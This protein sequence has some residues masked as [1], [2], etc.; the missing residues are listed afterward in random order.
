MS[1]EAVKS[2]QSL[3]NLEILSVTD[4]VY[5]PTRTSLSNLLPCSM[6][7]CYSCNILSLRMVQNSNGRLQ[8]RQATQAYAPIS[9]DHSSLS[10]GWGHV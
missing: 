8:L 6:Y 7:P 3:I 1:V 10:A 4:V 9:L 2:C 5:N